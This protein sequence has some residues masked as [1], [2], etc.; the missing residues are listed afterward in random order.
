MNNR[1]LTAWARRNLPRLSPEKREALQRHEFVVLP[2][3][4]EPRA[5]EW[6]L[7]LG[8]IRGDDGLSPRGRAMLAVMDMEACDG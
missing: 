7:C 1:D 2:V 4:D 8:P 6:L 5:W 3:S